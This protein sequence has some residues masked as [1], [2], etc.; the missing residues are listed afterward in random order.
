LDALVSTLDSDSAVDAL[1][2]WIETS[3]AQ[4]PNKA[5]LERQL[6]A[7]DGDDALTRFLHRFVLF[8][9]ALA[10]RVPFLAGL[11]HLT[12]NLFIDPEADEDFCGQAN[13]RIAAYVAE[14]AIDEYRMTAERS[15]VH[16]Y[17]SQ[18]F[19]HGVLDHYR[20]DGR[21]F[22]RRYPLPS[23]LAGFL[24]E[25]RGK[26]FR[27]PAPSDIFAALGF[28]VG[29]EFFA[30]QEFNVV[31]QYMRS[32]RPALVASLERE[33]PDDSPYL[34][35]ATHTVVE[36]G[37]YRAG[38]EALKSAVTFCNP[39]DEAPRMVACIKDGFEAFMD[40]QKRYY[41]TVSREL[42]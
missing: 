37:H 30:H 27:N 1:T 40:I 6:L 3:I 32:R 5:M 15:L 4:A 36:I 31:D 21:A 25:A 12:P 26:Y 13:G 18:L 19:F 17:L 11:I 2:A 10:A 42:S 7:I 33:E 35:L 14:A 38:L 20:M 22:D 16:Q 41:E 24:A 8:N 34:W 23:T 28:H 29:L 9:D 39:R